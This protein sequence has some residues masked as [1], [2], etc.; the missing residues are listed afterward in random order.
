MRRVLTVIQGVALQLHYAAR[1]LLVH[2]RP[3]LRGI[4]DF[5]AK[6]ATVKTYTDAICGLAST[7]TD[8]A[9][10]IMS[11]QCLFIGKIPRS[12]SFAISSPTFLAG[13]CIQDQRERLEV[14]RLL[15]ASRERAGW[16]F[17][18]LSDHLQMIWNGLTESPLP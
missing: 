12:V 2:H 18:P 4:G 17:N 13:L 7:L 14:V 8:D 5:M 1:I 11:S 9:S 3:C 16:P 6:Q 15:K 10:A